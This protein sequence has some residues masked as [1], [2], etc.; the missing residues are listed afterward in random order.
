ML[1]HDEV[2]GQMNVMIYNSP[3]RNSVIFL[4]NSNDVLGRSTETSTDE[5]NYRTYFGGN[6]TRDLPTINSR[7]HLTKIYNSEMNSCDV[8]DQY[9]HTHSI[10]YGLFILKMRGF[11]ACVTIIKYLELEPLIFFLTIYR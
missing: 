5:D 9:L 6:Y 11:L 2:D 3:G 1:I 8:Y 7:P 10:R 4:T